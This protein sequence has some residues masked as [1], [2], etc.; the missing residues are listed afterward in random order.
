MITRYKK[1]F[2]AFTFFVLFVVTWSVLVYQFSPQGIIERLGVTNGYG[3]AFFA[4]FLGGVS[5]FTSVP[6]VIIIITL[7]AGG[8]NPFLLGSVSA[9]GLFMGDITS[10]LLGYYGHNVVPNGLQSKLQRVHTWLMGRTRAW[11]IPIFIFIYGAFLPLSNDFVV[12]S[13]GL[14]RYPFW[15]MMIPLGLGTIVFNSILAFAGKYGLGYFL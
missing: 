9:L 5:T 11:T 2:I 10:Y 1:Q 15:R 4:A 14:A 7:G 3:V 13:F 12:I 6:Y 8:L